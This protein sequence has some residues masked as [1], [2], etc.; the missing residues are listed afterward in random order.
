M[1][2]EQR[3]VAAVRMPVSVRDELR[4][5]AR[6]RDVSMSYLVNRAVTEFLCQLAAP[7]EDAIT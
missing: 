2:D 1:Y 3:V 6:D 4:A 7:D 5:A